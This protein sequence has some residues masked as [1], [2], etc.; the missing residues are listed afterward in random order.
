MVR[1]KWKC[2]TIT[3]TGQCVMIAGTVLM[4]E[5]SADSWDSLRMVCVLYFSRVHCL[6]YHAPNL[7]V[8]PDHIPYRT[9]TPTDS[10]QPIL[11]DNM[12]CRGL[13]ENLLQCENNGLFVHN[14]DIHQTAGV[15]CGGNLMK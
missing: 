10:L 12:N 5:W 9:S 1:G 14:C 11:L 2:A 4:L 8:F 7:A 6:V 13:E 15:T 3:P